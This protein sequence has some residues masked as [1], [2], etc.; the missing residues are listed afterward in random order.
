MA[1][2]SFKLRL[3][4]ALNILKSFRVIAL[5]YVTE[6][7]STPNQGIEDLKIIIVLIRLFAERSI[8]IIKFFRKYLLNLTTVLK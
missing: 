7:L 6:I 5:F 1:L 4:R 3:R 8:R 2:S